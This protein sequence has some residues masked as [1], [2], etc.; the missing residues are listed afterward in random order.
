MT[1]FTC[2]EQ[3][4]AHVGLSNFL[5]SLYADYM[6]IRFGDHERDQCETGYALEWATRFK[7]GMEWHT[8]DLEGQRLL[9]QLAPGC[10][11][12]QEVV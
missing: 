9:R 6:R 5:T 12:K 4:A 7:N 11:P 3:V 10:Y 8:S 1:T 2:Y